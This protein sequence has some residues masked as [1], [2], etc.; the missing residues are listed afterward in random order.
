LAKNEIILDPGSHPAPR[1]LAGMTNY[2]TASQAEYIVMRLN[3][4]CLALYWGQCASVKRAED[5]NTIQEAEV[6]L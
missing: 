4:S 1:D 3:E 2:D 5:V 6:A